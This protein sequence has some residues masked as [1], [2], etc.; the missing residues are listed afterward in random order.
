MVAGLLA[1]TV[2]LTG[3]GTSSAGQ[4]LTLTTT[5]AASGAKTRIWTFSDGKYVQTA[6]TYA[7]ILAE[8]K[9]DLCQTAEH[10]T[11]AVELS[12]ALTSLE[13]VL[14]RAGGPGALDKLAQT[15]V[16]SDPAQAETVATA[17]VGKANPGGA[18]AVLLLAY[19]K[20][21]RDPRHLE[22]AGVVAASIGYPQEALA[23]L[24]EAE[25]LPPTVDPGMGVNY[26]AIELNNRAYALIRMGR[27]ADAIPLLHTA[28]GREPLLSEAQRNLAVALTCLG[29]LDEAGKAMRAGERRNQLQDFGD[30]SR[31]QVFDPSQVY[32]LS[33]GQPSKLPD[34]TYPQTL[35]QD[36]GATD[37]FE[38]D[39]RTRD[40]QNKQ[41]L[42]QVQALPGQTGRHYPLSSMRISRIE[43]LAGEV[44]GTPHVAQLWNAWQA[45]S[46]AA[47]AV[48]TKFFAD[49]G[50]Q[51]VACEVP[52]TDQ[53]KCFNDWCAGA[54][55]DA[56]RHWYTAIKTADGAL[57]AWADAYSRFASGMASNLSDP[58]A[59]Q[60]VLTNAQFWLMTAYALQLQQSS[61]WISGAAGFKGSCFDQV[62]DS[63]AETSAGG[64]PS[65]IPCSGV[66]GGANI[67]IDLE[68]FS[69]NV[70]CGEIGIEAEAPTLEGGFAE[71]GIFSSVTYKFKSGSTTLFAGDYAK[72]RAI[73]GLS[74]SA[75]GG[76]YI[77]WDNQGT[78][79]D[80][81]VK[82]E[83]SI[84]Q[85]KGA[86]SSSVSGPEAHWSF[87][88]AADDAE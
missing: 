5:P 37:K 18:L 34:V 68:L 38:T 42:Q 29:Q 69:I 67:S 83:T 32:D 78:V 70:S 58:A 33:R 62:T 1:L 65:A 20:Q 47:E 40:D 73:G 22:N 81:G 64:K 61:V 11:Q 16:G 85:S 27:Y 80:C 86:V 59:H 8:R 52:N 9:A 71:A 74:A 14:T 24:V 44:D 6:G 55:P 82:G 54:L 12:Q 57:R 7:T 28:I 35:D 49:A 46:K 3:C 76:G 31:P 45:D 87:V 88:G 10:G 50:N 79:T 15:K 60:Y 53:T 63:P 84:D 19:K 66:V 2:M 51:G 25:R 21:P 17:M 75:H 13:G 23:L 72:T 48:D 39:W 4:V 36:A 26:M 77:T 30:P 56:Q 41:L 43:V